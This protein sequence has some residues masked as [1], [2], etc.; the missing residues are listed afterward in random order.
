MS[1]MADDLI[2]FTS[3]L[4]MSFN[5]LAGRDFLKKKKF[6]EKKKLISVALPFADLAFAAGAVPVFPVRMEIFNINK[7]LL[8]MNSATTFFGWST[9]AKFLGFM[10]QFDSLKISDNII[11]EVIDSL[12]VQ[13]NSSYDL[14]EQSGMS[15]DFCYGLKA[16]YGMHVSKG[17]NVDAT[18]NF[19]FRC[20]AWNKYL[21]SIKTIVPKQI[22]LEMPPR[23]IGNSLELLKD[24][25]SKTISELE[26]LTGNNV[27]DNSLLKQFR[28]KNQITRYYKTIIYEI[29]MSDFYPCNPATFA[30]ILALLSIS[31]QDYNSDSV[32]YLDNISQLVKEMKERVKKGIGMDVSKMPKIMFTPM[33]GGWEPKI[34]E[35]IYELG[36]RVLYADW[37]VL[38]FLE[39]ID[40]T[41]D[42]IEGY[43]KFLM[44]F[45][46]N[47]VGC[48]NNTLTDSY[49]RVAKKLKADGLIF[50]QL[51]GC[52]SISNCYTM[53]REKLRRLEI[54]SIVLNFN[55]IG[56]G[57]EQV[58]TRLE[59]F[60]TFFDS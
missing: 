8:A 2:N 25:I 58:K 13:Y 12:N 46:V 18:F 60:M 51:F 16:L 59:T 31:F 9:V 57:I 37:D 29:G 38:G 27:T 26:E 48:D 17:K 53:L 56:D 5:F 1:T 42:P 11:A 24:N 35:I 52:H 21:E 6:R 45:T 36:G 3:M 39:E 28:I 33:F 20:S 14:G 47:G 30:E 55:K 19:T 50:N 4:K 40:V 23:N 54:P 43:A 7:Y 10:K 44:N 34:H 49:I 41:G 15:S 32:R 22:W